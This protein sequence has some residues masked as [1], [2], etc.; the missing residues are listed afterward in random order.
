MNRT[1]NI[2]AALALLTLTTAGTSAM[3][4]DRGD[5]IN[6]RMDARGERINDRLEDKGDRINDRLDERGERINDRLDQKAAVALA[7][8]CGVWQQPHPGVAGARRQGMA[9]ARPWRLAHL[10]A[11]RAPERAARHVAE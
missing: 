10:H 3:A 7:R 2:V 6:E 11:Q 4:E 8:H 1:K 5:R 9:E